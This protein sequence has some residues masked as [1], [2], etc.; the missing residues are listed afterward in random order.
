MIN[1]IVVPNQLFNKNPS[2]PVI[3]ADDESYPHHVRGGGGDDMNQLDGQ[4]LVAQ[5]QTL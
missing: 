2:A 3:A 4:V 1:A 5:P